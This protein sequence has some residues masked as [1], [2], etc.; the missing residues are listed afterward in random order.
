MAGRSM[1]WSSPNSNRVHWNQKSKGGRP[2]LDAFSLPEGINKRRDIMS[3]ENSKL[4]VL[5]I[6]N[7]TGQPRQ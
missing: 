3:K 6:N 7:R 4:R 5:T 2:R 1:T